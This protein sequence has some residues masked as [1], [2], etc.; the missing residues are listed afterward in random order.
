MIDDPIDSSEIKGRFCI[1]AHAPV[2]SLVGNSC[3]G[4]YS[5]NHSGSYSHS[6]GT[7]TD[8]KGKQIILIHKEIQN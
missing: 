5:R 7:Y 4:P 2:L 3:L 6:S 1:V 8:K